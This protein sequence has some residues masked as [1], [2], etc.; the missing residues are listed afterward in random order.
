MNH[1][2]KS[3]LLGIL[4]GSCTPGRCIANNISDGSPIAPPGAAR[5]NFVSVSGEA[6]FGKDP[7]YPRTDRFKVKAP[8]IDEQKNI[9]PPAVPDSVVLRGISFVTGKR[10]AIIN[11][12]TVAEGEEFSLRI[13]GKLIQG[14]CV[15]IKEKSVV[16]KVNGTSKE[17]SLRAALQ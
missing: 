7:F 10:L 15:E 8:R 1:S 4:M 13:D 2:Y 17:I 5:S 16:I 3:I 14:Q 9:E 11:N 12:Y 6:G